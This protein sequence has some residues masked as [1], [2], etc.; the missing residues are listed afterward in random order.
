MASKRP[1]SEVYDSEDDKENS[2][3][4]FDDSLVRIICSNGGILSTWSLIL[5]AN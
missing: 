4:Y 3:K 1:L 5:W 2:E